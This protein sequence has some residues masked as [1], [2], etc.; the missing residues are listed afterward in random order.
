MKAMKWPLS[1]S[2]LGVRWHVGTRETSS[3]REVADVWCDTLGLAGTAGVS[4]QK[5]CKGW[6]G[7][8]T[9]WTCSE[10]PYWTLLVTA[11]APTPPY[12]IAGLGHISLL[13]FLM[14]LIVSPNFHVES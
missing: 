5:G 14:G 3:A 11:P 2:R 13:A 4:R 10:S 12:P 7:G 9:L 6:G 8:V 1:H